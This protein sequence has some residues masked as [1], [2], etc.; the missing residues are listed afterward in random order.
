VALDSRV[1][2]GWLFGVYGLNVADEF[3]ESAGY[4]DRGEMCR[5]VVV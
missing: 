5:K 3:D 2:D 4:E 1:S